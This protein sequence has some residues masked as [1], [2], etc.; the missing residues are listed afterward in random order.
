MAVNAKLLYLKS[1]AL[2]VISNCRLIYSKEN[3]I[4]KKYKIK[5]QEKLAIISR[6]GSKA[7]KS[8]RSSL[9]VI[10]KM[11]G[12]TKPALRTKIAVSEGVDS[13]CFTEKV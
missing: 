6:V 8:S 4:P 7:E 2:S 9:S 3:F 10:L 12:K 13:V 1:F 11:R 5:S